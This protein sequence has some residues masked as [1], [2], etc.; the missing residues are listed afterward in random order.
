MANTGWTVTSQSSDQ[1]QV[2]P[3][4]QAIT[5]VIVY[6]TSSEGNHGSVFV[7]DNH[8]NAATVRK[9]VQARANLLDEIGSLAAQGG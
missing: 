3:A 4:G 6:F 5:G 9:M 2:T 8:Y 7:P 1:V